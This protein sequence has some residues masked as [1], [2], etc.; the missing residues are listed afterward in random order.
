[1]GS[2]MLAGDPLLHIEDDPPVSGK[3]IPEGVLTV[4]MSLNVVGA[5]VNRHRV[6]PRMLHCTSWTV[7]RS[8][9]SYR[10]ACDIHL[11]VERLSIKTH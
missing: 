3:Y 6:F 1:M 7:R 2:E 9:H 5:A 11:L 10:I 8:L 4:S